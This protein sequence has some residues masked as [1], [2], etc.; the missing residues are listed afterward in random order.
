MYDT[1]ST[2]IQFM[3]AFLSFAANFK[4]GAASLMGR[5]FAKLPNIPRHVFY[6]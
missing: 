3:K 1:P 5:S 4:P 6:W 2:K